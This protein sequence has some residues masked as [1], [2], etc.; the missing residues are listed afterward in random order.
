VTRA[1]QVILVIVIVFIAYAI[2]TSPAR[3]ADAVH[4]IWNVIVNALQAIF[5]FFDNLIKG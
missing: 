3:T 1:R 2:Y 5:T 4:A